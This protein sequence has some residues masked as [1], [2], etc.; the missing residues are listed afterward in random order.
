[1]KCQ[2]SLMLMLKKSPLRL[3]QLQ[4]FRLLMNRLRPTVALFPAKYILTCK[5]KHLFS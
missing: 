1:M 4:A 5:E 3:N 2:V